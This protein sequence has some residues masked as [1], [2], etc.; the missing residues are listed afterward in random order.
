[1]NEATVVKETVRGDLKFVEMSD[2]T[3]R[4]ESVNKV[5]GTQYGTYV[6]VEGEVTKEKLAKAKELVVEKICEMIKEIAN[7]S[8]EFFIVKTSD[9]VTSVAHK[10]ILPT[11]NDAVELNGR[12]VQTVK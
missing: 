7:K 11:V 10:F 8:E 2:G 4:V 5:S 9:D 3:I 1:M 6:L 12:T